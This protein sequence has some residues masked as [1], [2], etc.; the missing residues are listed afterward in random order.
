MHKS[1]MQTYVLSALFISTLL[2][3]GCQ[4]KDEKAVP[5]QTT[6][7]QADSLTSETITQG[8][9]TGWPVNNNWL[10]IH[11]EKGILL[12]GQV[13][14]SGRYEFGD[15]R[16]NTYVTFDLA[17]HRLV[18]FELNDQHISQIQK[19]APFD[20]PLEGMCLYQP[21]AEPLQA[22]LLDENQMAH[23]LA[24]TLSGDQIQLHKIRTLAV[25]PAAEYCISSDITQQLFVTE[26]GMGV[27]AYPASPEQE[28]KRTPVDLVPP[29]GNLAEGA[30]PLALVEDQLLVAGVG[31]N[32]LQAYKLSGNGFDLT[33][34]WQLPDEF[35][36]ETLTLSKQDNQ[37][38]LALFNDAQSRLESA[39][40]ELV[41]STPK[42]EMIPVIPASGETQPVNTDGDSADDPAIWVNSQ[43]P[44]QSLILG[45]NK[46]HGLSLYNLSG[47]EL[48]HLAVGRI[49]NVD[50]RKGF[51]LK[52]EEMDIA[53]AS[54][55]DLKAISLF[56]INPATGDTSSVGSIPTSLDDVY[57][58]CMYQNA[59]KEVFTFINDK[60]GR[61][62]QYQILDTDSGWQGQLV[63]AF[64]VPSQPEGC[65]ANDQTDE[66]FLGEE[67]A[68]I[69]KISAAVNGGTKPEKI[70]SISDMLVADIEG[71]TLYHTPEKLS[72]LVVSSQGND[73]YVV[74]QST[75][76]YQML[77]R[78]RVGM[79]ANLGIDGASE[80]DGLDVT[81]AYLGDT[82]P[83]GLLVVQDGRNVMPSEYQNFKLVDW[84][85]IE[86]ILEAYS[87]PK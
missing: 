14:L 71:M 36:A 26:E 60:D 33:A 51:S 40:I 66:L 52:G 44:E 34:H 74:Y 9:E 87:E 37:L 19:S 23:H 50:L 4:N 24:L 46:K 70:I 63:R 55:R 28:I 30:G 79:N 59:M 65:V 73:S 20:Y 77:G 64:S 61:F 84:V 22:F 16:G 57:G 6:E 47:Q 56:A 82:Y 13:L 8:A 25:P 45:T 35:E 2:L 62:E 29:Y 75:A 27:W 76:P 5:I 1:D 10:T 48:Q 85:S 21:E 68:A 12:N 41:T 83:K 72:Y 11:S 78:F 54:H 49:N 86:K 32:Q 53:T 18:S 7:K 3:S 58:L 81:N 42:T 80:T 15:R 17:E 67:N 38:T 31:S 43:A 39:T 69:W